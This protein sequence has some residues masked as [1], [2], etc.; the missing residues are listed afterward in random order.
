MVGMNDTGTMI[1]RREGW[2]RQTDGV[3]T[4]LR[5]MCLYYPLLLSNRTTRV[6][7]M[8]PHSYSITHTH[9]THVC[10]GWWTTHIGAAIIF[11][12]MPLHQHA[13]YIP[14]RWLNTFCV[15]NIHRACVCVCVCASETLQRSASLN[16]LPALP[17]QWRQLWF[18]QGG[19]RRKSSL[20]GRI[21]VFT[22]AHIF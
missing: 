20:K 7:L 12:Q 17:S 18:L 16:P 4:K 10:H 22:S 11:L 2:T 14:A 3:K 13:S 8:S 9:S 5:N 21:C 1:S 15:T 6:P 19:E